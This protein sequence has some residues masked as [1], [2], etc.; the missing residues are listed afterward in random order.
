[1][2]IF[3]SGFKKSLDRFHWANK[4]FHFEFKLGSLEVT[5]EPYPV[6]TPS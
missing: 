2:E 4:I 3:K 1:M 6:L 5:E